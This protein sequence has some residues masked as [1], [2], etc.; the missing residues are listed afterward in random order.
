[1]ITKNNLIPI[2]RFPN[3]YDHWHEIKLGNVGTF[4]N[5]LNKDKNDFGFGYPF[6]NLLDVFG[7]STIKKDEYDLVNATDRDLKLYNFNK[8]DVLFIRSSVKREGVGET[9]LVIENLP[10]TVYSGFLI[11]FREIS[12]ILELPF[13]K[14]CFLIESF[15]R[16]LLSYATTSANTNINQESLAKLYIRFP[17]KPEQK[18]IAGFLS[19]VDKK[20]ENLTHKKELLEQFKKGVTQKI[21]SLKIR[22][23]QDDGNAYPDWEEKQ[24]SKFLKPAFRK[25][26]K[27]SEPYLAIG[28]RSHC[29]G[30]FKKPKSDPNKIAMEKLFVVKE[31][32][33]VVNITFAWEGAIALI[34]KEDDGGLV[35]HRFPTYTFNRKEVLNEFFKYIIIQKRFRYILGVLSPGGA[36]RNR[37]LSKNDFLKIKWTLPLIDEQRKITTFLYTIEQKTETISNQLIQTQQFRKGLL[38]Q[39]FV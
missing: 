27:P 36:G 22:F 29:K 13:K 12:Q 20:I 26:P 24:L 32:D 28:I 25:I 39:M 9:I 7:N 34:K 19:A 2:L 17:S 11:R 1:M 14:Y 10:K 37:V 3:Y 4:K 8:G 6:I 16:Q 21:F 31:S 33:L 23:K 38:Q 18:K 5:G 15:R 30:T 35:S